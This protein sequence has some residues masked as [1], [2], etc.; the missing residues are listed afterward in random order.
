V[1]VE[2]LIIFSC[3]WNR[4]LQRLTESE[5]FHLYTQASSKLITKRIFS[6]LQNIICAQKLQKHQ[7]HD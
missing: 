5:D 2:E 3:F 4:L 7:E 6:R 1:K